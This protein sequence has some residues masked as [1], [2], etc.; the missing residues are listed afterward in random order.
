M[1][2][3]LIS[4]YLNSSSTVYQYLTLPAEHKDLEGHLQYVHPPKQGVEPAVC[5]LRLQP[6]ILAPLTPE[7]AK[8]KKGNVDATS[9]TFED[10]DTLVPR[11]LRQKSRVTLKQQ[12]Y[13]KSV[14]LVQRASRTNLSRA[15]GGVCC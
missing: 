12:E 3:H 9:E 15:H 8:P 2:R 1:R 13:I 4:S 14:V 6:S 10:A 7:Q 5:P 11:R